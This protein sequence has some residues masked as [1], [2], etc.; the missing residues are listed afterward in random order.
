ME[1][2]QIATVFAEIADILEILGEQDNAF[3]IRSYRNAARTIDAL[4][5]RLAD[6]VAGGKDPADLPGI[7]TSLAGKIHEI[8]RTGTCGKLKEL[9]RQLPGHLPEL[10]QVKGIGPKP[11]SDFMTNWESKA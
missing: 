4:P 3:R 9:R 8:L 10:L 7:G 1:N 2:S 11:A 6:L 5:D